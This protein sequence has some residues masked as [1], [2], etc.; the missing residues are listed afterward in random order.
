MSW[1]RRYAGAP[2]WV[3]RTPILR[4]PAV[5]VQPTAV[6]P[7]AAA[8]SQPV[9]RDWI[10]VLAM[11][12]GLF[13]AIMDVQIV[14]SSFVPDPGR[15]VGERRRDLVRVDRLSDRRRRHG[16]ADR[17][18]VAAVVDARPVRFRGTRLYRR[19][20]AVRDGDEPRADDHFSRDA[21][22]LRRRDLAER[23]SGRLHAVPGAASDHAD[24]A[25]L[26]HST[27]CSFDPQPNEIGG[28]LTD[29]F[30]WNWL[31]LVNIV[32]GIAVTA[33]VWTCIDIDKPPD[34]SLL[35]YFD[36]IGLVLMATFLGCLEYALE[37]GPRW[38]WLE[39]ARRSAPRS[40]YPRQ[41]RCCSS[42]G[43]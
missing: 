9:L 36:V 39:A 12:V 8:G 13:M 7:P 10:G 24:G 19:E 14:T 41:H 40:S 33:V 37:E 23:V 15:V 30:S 18:A 2:A 11:A 32:P 3:R 42:G 27:Y 1:A 16:A 26:G 21:R 38:D 6:A 4:T 5:R 28:F 31:F 17:D 29:T 35:R 43:C 20:Q 22:V 34:L 25:D